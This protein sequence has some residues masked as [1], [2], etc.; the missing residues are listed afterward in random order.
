M[1]VEPSKLNKF[2]T[3]LCCEQG[4]TIPEMAKKAGFVPSVVYK[5]LYGR[6]KP[7]TSSMKKLAAGIGVPFY[8][9]L[10]ATGKDNMAEDAKNQSSRFYKYY[11]AHG[12]TR[13][14]VADIA[15]S[16]PH[17]IWCWE[18]GLSKPQ[19]AQYNR[20][21]EHFGVTGAELGLSPYKVKNGVHASTIEPN[22][23]PELNALLHEIDDLGE[24]CKRYVMA[25]LSPNTEKWQAQKLRE[26]RVT[27]DEI[28]LIR[29]R[30][31]GYKRM[32]GIA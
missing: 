14:D 21:C 15:K 3:E 28:T 19:A 27:D 1:N 32:W 23:T 26:G 5:W 7:T 25:Y 13:N 20:L 6:T 4:L 24:G 18:R 9:L 30:I 10:S 2:I 11:T 17:T 22:Y 8:V 16:S 12:M 31:D 29:Q